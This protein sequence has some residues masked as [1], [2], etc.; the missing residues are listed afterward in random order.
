[1]KAELLVVPDHQVLAQQVSHPETANT[2]PRESHPFVFVARPVCLN[3]YSFQ[4]YAG[5][6]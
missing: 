3:T 1:M 2:N 5:W 6:R 4:W